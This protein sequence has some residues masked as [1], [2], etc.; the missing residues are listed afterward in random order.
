MKFYLPTYEECQEIVSKNEFF[1][2]MKTSVDGYDIS[3]FNYRLARSEDFLHPIPGKDIEASELRGLTFIHN[4]GNSQRFLMLHKFFNLNQVAG[5]QYGEL[6]N[7][8][9]VRVQDKADGSMIAFVRLPNGRI[10]A[11]T[12]MG[13]DNDQALLAQELFKKDK[14]LQEFVTESL[15]RGLV[16]IYELCSPLNRIVLRY[17]KTELRLLQIRSQETGEYLDT[18][19][20]DLVIKH[21]IK[22]VDRETPKTLDEYVELA[23]STKGIEGWVLTFANQQMVKLKTEDYFSL[24][25][26]LTEKL[27]RENLILGLV[28]DDTI[29]D[30]ISQLDMNDIRRKA[31][32]IVQ[33]AIVHYLKQNTEVVLKLI[34]QYNGDKKSWAMAHLK[35]EFFPIAAG[36]LKPHKDLVGEIDKRLREKLKDETFRLTEARAWL[37]AR[38]ISIGNL[39]LMNDEDS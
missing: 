13:F 5:Y 11:K 2:E 1:Y 16:T 19:S 26:L 4:E 22:V 27:T 38:G 6:K 3:V 30:A 17:S 33:A 14:E 20:N 15:N 36:L 25:G 37:S 34:S 31:A 35:E 32:N 12:K 8:D 18:Y 29:D 39:E 28:L 7:L 24:H 21:G 10:V 23:K 9:I